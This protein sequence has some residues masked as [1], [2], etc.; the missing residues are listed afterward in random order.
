MWLGAIL[1]ALVTACVP[2]AGGES[3]AVDGACADP[4]NVVSMAGDALAAAMRTALELE[5]DAALSR[6]AVGRL[7][8]LHASGPLGVARQRASNQTR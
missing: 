3:D 2:A 7:R 5:A 6:D 4:T 8:T 1:I